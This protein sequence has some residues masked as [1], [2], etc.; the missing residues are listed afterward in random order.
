MTRVSGC[1]RRRDDRRVER[2][3]GD[4]WSR[5]EKGQEGAEG[6][7][8]RR[9]SQLR[10]VRRKAWER[11]LDGERGWRLFSKEQRSSSE[12]KQLKWKLNEQKQEKEQ[13][14]AEKEKMERAMAKME[15]QQG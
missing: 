8:R 2:E 3:N 9:E 13:E 15:Q 14:K 6:S 10:G 12:M 11:S 1:S 7:K 4:R 5:G